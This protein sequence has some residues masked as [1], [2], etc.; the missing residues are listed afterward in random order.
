MHKDEVFV[1]T[2]LPADLLTDVG[3]WNTCGWPVASASLGAS[4]LM[5]DTEVFD[6]SPSAADE[7]VA[8]A[9]IR[10]R[11]LTKDDLNLHILQSFVRAG[12]SVEISMEQICQDIYSCH[13]KCAVDD[14]EATVEKRSTAL[15]RLFQSES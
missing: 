10:R 6:D 11:E 2:E 8:H 12:T 5:G 9:T 14:L 7:L 4:A 3:D 1:T 13:R 15:L